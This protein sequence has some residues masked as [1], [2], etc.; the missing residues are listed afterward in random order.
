MKDK[1]VRWLKKPLICSFILNLVVGL[2]LF[3][4]YDFHWET[5]DDVYMSSIAYGTYGQYDEHLVFINIIIGRLLKGLLTLCPWIP[6]YGVLQTVIVFVSFVIIGYRI[7]DIRLDFE[8]L[9]IS[10]VMIWIMGLQFYVQM[11]FTKTAGIASI[12]GILLILRFCA[13]RKG[14][15]WISFI[16][17]LVMC[18]VGIMYRASTFYPSFAILF[19]LGVYELIYYHNRDIVKR[20][21]RYGGCAIL[22]LVIMKGLVAYNSSQYYEDKAYKDYLE[23]SSIRT[24]LTDYYWPDYHNNKAGYDELGISDLDVEFYSTWNL[25]DKAVINTQNLTTIDSFKD[26]DNNYLEN[27]KNIKHFLVQFYNVFMRYSFN[28]VVLLVIVL[29]V[30]KEK[31]QKIFLGV[32]GFVFI[33]LQLYLYNKGRVF[34]QRV[35]AVFVMAF[36]SSQFVVLAYGKKERK[37]WLIRMLMT[38][39]PLTLVNMDG[40]NTTDGISKVSEKEQQEWISYLQN[41]KD[42]LFMMES[43]TNVYLMDSIYSIWNTPAMGISENVYL[44]GGWL[45]QSPYTNGILDKYGIDNPMQ[46]MV[47]NDN[48]SFVINGNTDTFERYIER[49]YYDNV[50]FEFVNKIGDICIYRVAEDN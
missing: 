37:K 30:N 12:A 19:V 32:S 31:K 42:T 20:L 48:V 50:K 45:Y 24:K 35:D 26:D 4:I 18:S 43:W 33:S 21:L 49:H 38:M 28:I 17:G 6:W 27:N 5:N 11:Q 7:F 23:F 40:Q 34:I 8:M 2:I 1:C 29:A 9:T 47:G 10:T 44:L 3:L 46:D 25:A 16:M 14:K 22:L 41:N 39:L 13:Q 36:I 15:N